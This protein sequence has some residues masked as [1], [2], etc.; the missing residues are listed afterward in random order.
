MITNAREILMARVL[1]HAGTEIDLDKM[2]YNSYNDH[3][4]EVFQERNHSVRT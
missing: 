1:W 4:R 3:E 2:R